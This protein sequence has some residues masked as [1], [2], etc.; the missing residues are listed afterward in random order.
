MA[1]RSR[2]A[3]GPAA[4]VSSP[5]TSAA[6]PSSSRRSRSS[7]SCRASTAS[8][9]APENGCTGT[10]R[11]LPQRVPGRDVGG[12]LG[13]RAAAH[14]YMR[15]AARGRGQQRR[16]TGQPGRAQVLIQAV[17]DQQQVTVLCRR[18]V[19]QLAATAPGTG[20]SRQPGDLRPAGWPAA[21]PP[22]PGI[23]S[24]LRRLPGGTGNSRRHRLSGSAITASASSAVF[25]AHASPTSHRYPSSP[26]ANDAIPASSSCRPVSIPVRLRISCTV[27]QYAG[28]PRPRRRPEAVSASL[29][30]ELPAEPTTRPDPPPPVPSPDALGPPP[31]QSAVSP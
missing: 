14:Q 6:S 17:D 25:P 2:T 16:D 4:A 27:A 23:A 12:E 1:A 13:M 28:L 20:A 29:P 30:W 7:I 21:G 22:R 11:A 24:C 8:S 15:A 18:P 31:A 26:A 19:R 5:S 9:C 3:S 10:G